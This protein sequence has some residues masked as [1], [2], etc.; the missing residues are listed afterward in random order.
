MIDLKPNMEN[1]N[2]TC[3]I[4][5]YNESERILGVLEAVSKVKEF[6][7]IICVDDGSIDGSIRQLADSKFVNKKIYPQFRFLRLRKNGGKTGAIEASLKFVTDPLIFLIDGDLL[8][9]QSEEIKKAIEIMRT[10]QTIS[11]IILCRVHTN[12][13]GAWQR[14]NT[15]FSGERILK[16][17]DLKRVLHT[18][19]KPVGYQLE[20]A[21]NGYIIQSNKRAYWIP[22]SAINHF[23]RI[24]YKYFRLF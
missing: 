18:K 17:E 23:K 4:P 1:K 14:A 16:T 12:I 24:K 9:L 21:I 2:V 20:I 6:S 22:S 11:M 19:P 7:R 8:N 15:I 5:F 10:D 3:I 13:Q